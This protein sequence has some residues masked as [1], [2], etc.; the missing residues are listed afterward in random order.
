MDTVIDLCIDNA[1]SIHNSDLISL[2]QFFRGL[3]D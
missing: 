2:K 1:L 3:F